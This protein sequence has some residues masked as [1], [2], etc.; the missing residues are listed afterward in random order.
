M[1]IHHDLL[2]SWGAIHRKVEKGRVIFC[3]AE[4][5][6]FYYQIVSGEVRMVNIGTSGREFIQGLSGPGDP[7]GE[8]ALLTGQPYI[9]AAIANVET[10]LLRLPRSTFLQLLRDNPDAHFAFT[11]HLA[12]RLRLQTALSKDICTSQPAHLISAL[13]R[14][15]TADL[16]PLGNGRTRVNLTRQQIADMTGLR[17]ETV[18]RIIRGLY[19]RGELQLEK[20]KV[21]V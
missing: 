3:E 6:H 9:A 13:L 20:G 7:I 12:C 2:T 21:Y 18:I 14:R 16:S 10:V 19:K 5:P 17:V 1:T 15:H 8:T 4:I 11:C